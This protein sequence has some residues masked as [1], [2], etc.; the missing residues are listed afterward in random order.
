MLQI[1]PK[2]SSIGIL[3]NGFVFNVIFLVQSVEGH[4]VVGPGSFS[5]F[6]FIESELN[7]ERERVAPVF[8]YKQARCDSD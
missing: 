1:V 8:F 5:T 2:L 3:I 7:S 6:T 4:S